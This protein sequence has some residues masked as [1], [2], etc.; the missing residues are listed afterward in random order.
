VTCIARPYRNL[1]YEGIIRLG[2]FGWNETVEQ[3]IED[4][5]NETHVYYTSDGT[6]HNGIRVVRD[7]AS[8]YVQTDTEPDSV[9]NLLNL[10]DC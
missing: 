2:G 1:G 7:G 5:A 4:I 8:A 10:P 3:V 6:T 9:N